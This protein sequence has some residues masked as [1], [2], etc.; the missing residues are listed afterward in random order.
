MLAY[1]VRREDR[2]GIVTYGSYGKP[3]LVFPSEL[4]KRWDWEDTGMIDALAAADRGGALKVY[5][6]DG[7]GRWN[8]ARGDVPLEER[9]RRHGDYERWIAEHVVAVGSTRTAR[10]RRASSSPAPASAPTT[11]RT[12]RCKRADLFPLA[13][14]HERRVR[15][16]GRRLG[17]ARRRRL[18][19]QPD[20]LRRS[21]CTATTSTG[22]ARAC[23]SL[24]VVRPGAVGGHDRRA[25]VDEAVRVA[26]RREGNPRT[27]S[28]SGDTTSPHDWPSWRAQITHHLARF[29]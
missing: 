29:V 16:L 2:D 17:R 21:T 4:G 15:R 7:C 26:A 14:L 24:L 10:S 11:P 5:C 19:Q 23:R 22:C 20:R 27:S 25:R 1:G 13:D 6:V 8:V 3:L 28:T 9:A 18:L 12:S